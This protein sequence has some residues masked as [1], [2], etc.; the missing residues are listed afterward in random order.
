[1]KLKVLDI[2]IGIFRLGPGER[3]PDSI[4]GSSF[5]SITRTDE[6]LSIVCDEDFL[7]GEEFVE[8]G[9]SLIK[10]VGPFQFD[11]TGGLDNLL[12]PLKDADIPVFVISTYD[13]DYILIKKDKLAQA[14]TIFAQ[15]QGISVL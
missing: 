8:K 14:I 15:I 9:F 12:N 10:L 5:L 13:T 11:E 6:E 3:I 4:W 2:H 7:Q 1:M